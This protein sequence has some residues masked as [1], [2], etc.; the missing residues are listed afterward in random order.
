MISGEVNGRAGSLSSATH[1][2]RC[3]GRS[4]TRVRVPSDE[5]LEDWD[6]GST[7]QDAQLGVVLG[8]TFAER[9]ERI[10]FTRGVECRW[11]F[12]PT[13]RSEGEDSSVAL[14]RIP[15]LT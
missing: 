13:K 7:V 3:C 1:W 9:G 11:A 6:W 4:V 10:R 15:V 14:R 12:R 5:I 8:P 2:L